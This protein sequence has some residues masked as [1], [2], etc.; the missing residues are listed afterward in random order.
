MLYSIHTLLRILLILR[1]ILLLLILLLLILLL[2]KLLLLLIL[3]LLIHVFHL[4]WSIL[5]WLNLRF[6]HWNLYRLWHYR[7]SCLRIMSNSAKYSIFI[8]L[9]IIH[10]IPLLFP[11]FPFL[12]EP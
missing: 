5:L 9:L 1:L 6:D 8:A 11:S 7:L 2:L 3:L 10:L 4:L 12:S